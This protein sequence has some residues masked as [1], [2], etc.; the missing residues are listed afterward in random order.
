MSWKSILIF[1]LLSSPL[2]AL[3]RGEFGSIYH[4]KTIFSLYTLIHNRDL[5]NKWIFKERFGA[6]FDISF[7]ISPQRPYPV[8]KLLYFTLDNSFSDFLNKRFTYSITP[9]FLIRTWIPL[10]KF[11]VT[12]GINF[13]FEELK[14]I[15]SGLAAQAMVEF[16]GI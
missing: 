13:R 10:F 3:D 6:G 2:F 14:K 9:G 15:Y 4:K 12:G 7:L 8:N 5:N 1:I 11:G 16:H